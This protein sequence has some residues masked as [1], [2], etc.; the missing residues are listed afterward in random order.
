MRR[1]LDDRWMLT[2]RSVLCRPPADFKASH[3]LETGPDYHAPVDGGVF[4]VTLEG[5][6][7]RTSGGDAAILDT[8]DARLRTS[9]LGTLTSIPCPTSI[10]GHQRRR[11]ERKQY[12]NA[13]PR[14]PRV[15]SHVHENRA[16]ALPKSV[17]RSVSLTQ[18]RGMP[19]LVLLKFWESHGKSFSA[20]CRRL[21]ENER[22][23]TLSMPVEEVS[24]TLYGK[25]S[26]RGAYSVVSGSCPVCQKYTVV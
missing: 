20:W 22:R 5:S 3:I 16:S 11:P 17:T 25:H 19:S 4:W 15:T 7:S 1:H 6:S 10:P 8:P 12:K 9:Q 23:Q 13:V 24:G 18:S 2:S 26:L 21:S 14:I